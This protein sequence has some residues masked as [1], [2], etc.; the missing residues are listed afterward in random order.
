MDEP[1]RE[2]FSCKNLDEPIKVLMNET[3]N[4]FEPDNQFGE[5]LLKR[6]RPHCIFTINWSRQKSAP[7]GVS[8]YNIDSSFVQKKKNLGDWLNFLF[9]LLFIQDAWFAHFSLEE[10]ANYKNRL[11]WTI[12]K[13]VKEPHFTPGAYVE[14][15]F[16][17][18]L[19]ENIPGVYWGNYFGPFY[20]KFLGEKKFQDLPFVQK[21][22]FENG[23]VFFTSAETPFD[24]NSKNCLNLQRRIMHHLGKDYFFD[25]EY[26]RRETE[27]KLGK[28]NIW[29]P[30]QLLPKVEVPDFPF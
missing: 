21:I 16:G 1:L 6:N 25:M 22:E 26:L 9:P 14:S 20:V 23:G 4:Q 17:T 5:I 28:G 27:E 8:F 13:N 18:K 15:Y 11:D 2:K 19:Q 3:S 29:N 7:F 10:E 12:P 24:W 30:S